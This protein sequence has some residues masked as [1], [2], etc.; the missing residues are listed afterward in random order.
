M[1]KIYTAAGFQLLEL[2]VTLSI[3]CILA[4]VGFPT[5]THHVNAARRVQATQVLSQLALAMEKYHFEHLSYRGASLQAFGLEE[6]I[7]DG[8]YSLEIAEA[9]DERYVISAVPVDNTE[10]AITLTS[11]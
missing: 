8:R 4:G 7:A 11:T 10:Q 3:V 9:T 5:Y 6:R 2:L 1:K